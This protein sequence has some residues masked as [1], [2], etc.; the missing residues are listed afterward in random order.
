MKENEI[1]PLGIYIL[2]EEKSG[3][4]SLEFQA[5]GFLSNP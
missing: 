4:V 3:F 5:S 1:L 2:G